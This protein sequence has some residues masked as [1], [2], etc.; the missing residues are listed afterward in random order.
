MSERWLVGRSD[1]GLDQDVALFWNKDEA[2]RYA[3]WLVKGNPGISFRVK[4]T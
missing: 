1:Q 3:E 4:L 2:V